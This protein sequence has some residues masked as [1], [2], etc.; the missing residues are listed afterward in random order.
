MHFCFTLCVCFVLR[1]TEDIIL[2]APVCASVSFRCGVLVLGSGTMAF[3]S[4][5]VGFG[6]MRC[7]RVCKHDASRMESLNVNN[8]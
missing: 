7:L 4:F 5:S 2:L 1:V 8:Y 6:V 3:F